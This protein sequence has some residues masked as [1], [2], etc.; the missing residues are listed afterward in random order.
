MTIDATAALLR[1]VFPGAPRIAH[2][3][4]L[5]WLYQSSPM[6][7]VV[8]ANLDD[9][10]GR[11]GHYALMPLDLTSDGAP[12]A[13]ALSLNTAVHER[14]RGGGVFVQLAAAALDTAQQRGVSA[15]IG[16]ANANS[17]PGFLRRLEFELVAPLPATMLLPLPGSRRGV[18]SA[19][20]D[21]A[22]D[23]TEGAEPLVE[24]TSAQ[25]IATAWTTARLRW[26]LGSPGSRYALHRS[27][28]ALA[29][30]TADQ[31]HGVPVA[32]LLAV[33][34]MSRLSAAMTRALVR[35]ACRFHRAPLALHVGLND[36][37]DFH[38]VPLPKRLR[39]SPLNL[40]YR[41][42]SGAARP[43]PV[44][45]FELLDFDAY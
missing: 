11:A 40:I 36:Q 4:Y 1:H 42:L 24:R 16:V 30:T 25:G 5:R 35:A 32:I 28:Q 31:R 45:R 7:P 39:E 37:V 26:R 2:A 29:V 10:H 15:V 18:R 43:G 19:W 33:F 38:G 8:E 34:T 13:G 6:G 22:P 9:E 23:L 3:D 20:A 21:D 44:V 17:T 14:A 12:L 27:E 41:D